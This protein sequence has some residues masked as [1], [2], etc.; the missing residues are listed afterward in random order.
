MDQTNHGEEEG[1]QEAKGWSVTPAVCSKNS[2]LIKMA[3]CEPEVV[4]SYGV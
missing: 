4:L 2:R 3:V 1:G